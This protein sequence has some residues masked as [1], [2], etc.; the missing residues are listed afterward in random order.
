MLHSLCGVEYFGGPAFPSCKRS[1]TRSMFHGGL[2]RFT[3]EYT[4]ASSSW[5]NGASAVI[6]VEIVSDARCGDCMGAAS[7]K[8]ERG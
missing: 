5:L 2:A 1:F 4:K 7:P 6:G 8:L 3:V